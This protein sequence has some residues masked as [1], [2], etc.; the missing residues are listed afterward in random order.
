MLKALIDY[1]F[2]LFSDPYGI[3]DDIAF[4]IGGVDISFG[5]YLGYLCAYISLIIIIVLCCLFIYRLIR[6]VGRLFHG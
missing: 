5:D 4:N 3:T 6:L 2:S 1:F